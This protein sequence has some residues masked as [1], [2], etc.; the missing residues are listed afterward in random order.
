MTTLLFIEK[1]RLVNSQDIF[2]R[3]SDGDRVVNV[4]SINIH[5]RQRTR[6]WTLFKPHTF[7]VSSRHGAVMD[8]TKHNRQIGSVVSC[9]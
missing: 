6:L 3:R 1:A 5:C 4:A 8:K 2:R 7:T 9:Y